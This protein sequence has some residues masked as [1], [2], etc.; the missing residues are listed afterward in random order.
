MKKTYT[1]VDKWEILR[2]TRKRF[3]KKIDEDTKK[4]LKTH[5]FKIKVINLLYK[6][7]EF[8]FNISKKKG[9]V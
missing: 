2:V 7:W 5:P 8:T 3:F 4:F 9:C 6:R 1:P